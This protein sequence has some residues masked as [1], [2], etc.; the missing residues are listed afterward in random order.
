MEEEIRLLKDKLHH[1]QENLN[2]IAGRLL[3]LQKNQD[4]CRFKI[5]QRV[6]FS[7]CWP[8]YYSGIIK[9]IGKTYGSKKD[10]E[11]RY[12]YNSQWDVKEGGI[13]WKSVDGIF[14]NL[15]EYKDF[16]HERIETLVKD[17]Q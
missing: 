13:L 2:F 15:R 5:G 7:S 12:D 14:L 8:Y 9:N 3:D 16:L 17:R 1:C 6:Y 11:I 10:I 4:E